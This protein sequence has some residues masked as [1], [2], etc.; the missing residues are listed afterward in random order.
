MTLLREWIKIESKTY[1]KEMEKYNKVWKGVTMN[2]V[3]KVTKH[4]QVTFPF[5]H[6][7]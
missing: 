7:H 4:S 3:T 5:D 6:H 1:K 2:N